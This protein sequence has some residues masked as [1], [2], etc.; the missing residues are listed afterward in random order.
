MQRRTGSEKLLVQSMPYALTKDYIVRS[1]GCVFVESLS[2]VFERTAVMNRQES[3]DQR[4][5]SRRESGET[6][7]Q[8]RNLNR[9]DQVSPLNLPCTDEIEYDTIANSRRGYDTIGI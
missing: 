4:L 7:N 9:T 6:V 5:K 1:G 8:I 2:G 3:Q